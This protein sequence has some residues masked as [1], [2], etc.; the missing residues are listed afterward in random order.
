LRLIHVNIVC[1]DFDRSYD[2]YTKGIGLKPVLRAADAGATQSGTRRLGEWSS[3]QEREEAGYKYDVLDFG[4][5]GVYRA[6]FLYWGESPGMPYL[7][8][9]EWRERGQPVRRTA[10]DPGYARIAIEVDDLDAVAARLQDLGTTV[11]TEPRVTN[12][13]GIDYR[14]LLFRDPDGTLLELV[15][16]ARP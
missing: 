10:Q 2:F 3:P 12:V 14:V 13:D 15:Q 11:V 8:L 6:V 7:D 4:G 16:S 9:L 5:D 1:T